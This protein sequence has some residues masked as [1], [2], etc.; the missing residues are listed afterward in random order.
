MKINNETKVGLLVIVT[1][2]LLIIGFNFLKGKD[3]FSNPNTIYA[4]FDDIGT[5]SKGN[6]V[7]IK[8]LQIGKVYGTE[9]VDKDVSAIKVTIALDKDI[10]IPVDSY[11]YIE[12]S[13]LSTPNLAIVRGN[14][15]TN[16]IK[17]GSEIKAMSRPGGM[18]SAM[19]PQLDPLLKQVGQTIDSLNLILS[20]VNS[21]FDGDTKVNLQG[22]LRNLN[23]STAKLEGILSEAGKG[24][25]ATLS[26]TESI[27]ANLR[28][29]NDSINAILS[30]AKQFSDGLAKV[31]LDKMVNTINGMLTDLKAVVTKMSSTDGTLGALINDK[32]VYNRLN[33]AILSAEI[34]MDDLRAHPKRY[35][36]ISVF[37]KKDKSGPLTSPAVKDTLP[38]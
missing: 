28:K 19:A 13:L 8:G 6:A 14:D 35:V 7:K 10:N 20:N 3:L 1:L 15:K 36:N 27:T 2:A 34:L 18:L 21:I 23:N 17:Y 30:N 22:T 25:N 26:N 4:Y 9:N 12:P 38:K 5:I 16:F 11:I 29:N 31:D 32:Q 37:G 33:N 24:I